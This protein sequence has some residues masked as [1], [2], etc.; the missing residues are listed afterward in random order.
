M[1]M[2]IY[3]KHGNELFNIRLKDSVYLNQVV[4]EMT[5]FLREKDYLDPQTE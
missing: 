2:K 1:E 3:D 4:N 5:E